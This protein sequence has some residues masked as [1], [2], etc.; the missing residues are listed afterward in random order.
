MWLPLNYKLDICTN[1]ITY[2]TTTTIKNPSPPLYC[3]HTEVKALRDQSLQSAKAVVQES[4]IRSGWPSLTHTKL[5]F[6]ADGAEP[7]DDIRWTKTVGADDG[8]CLGLQTEA[9]SWECRQGVCVVT[10]HGTSSSGRQKHGF[11]SRWNNPQI[12][13]RSELLACVRVV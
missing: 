8:A 2:R 3:I 4:A 7:R 6:L 10:S 12:E 5:R 1:D 13:G 9:S 11:A